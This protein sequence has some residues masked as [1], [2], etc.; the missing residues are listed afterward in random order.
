MDF[1]INKKQIDIIIDT[2]ADPVNARNNLV[3]KFISIPV[4]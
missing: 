2:A 4:S 1:M 3:I